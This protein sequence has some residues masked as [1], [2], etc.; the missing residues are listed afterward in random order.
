MGL[1][2]DVHLDL[3]MGMTFPERAEKRVQSR[4]VLAGQQRQDFPSSA[5]K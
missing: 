3:E 5:S 4:L 1:A 2:A